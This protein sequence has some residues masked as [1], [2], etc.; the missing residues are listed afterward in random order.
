MKRISTSKLARRES[1]AAFFFLLPAAVMFITFTIIPLFTSFGLMFTKWD[2]LTPAKPV[3]LVNFAKLFSDKRFGA[4]VG[5]TLIYAAAGV[6]LKVSLGLLVAQM[7]YRLRLKFVSATLESVYFF[8]VIL[9]MS[10]VA[11]VWGILFNTGMGA[12][13]SFLVS[14]GMARVP[15]L[16]NPQWAKVTIIMLDVWKGLGFFF[17]IYL[18]AL[19]NVPRDFYEAASID[20]AKPRQLFWHITWPL[21]SPTTLFLSINALIGSLQIFD[22]PY[23]LTKGGPGDATLS[24]VNYIYE[25]AF[26]LRNMGYAT[27]L[28]IVLLLFTLLVT[29]LQFIASKRWVHYT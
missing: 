17:I 15:W 26:Q 16:T 5:N 6:V 13:N 8:P 19:R 10:I 18:V 4:V 24:L 7:V 3:G 27:T 29:A 22:G 25:T 11:M 21:I 23:I 2:M 14:W 28:A 20:G 12:V 1:F 9:P